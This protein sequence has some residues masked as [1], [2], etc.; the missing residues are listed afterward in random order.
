M[1]TLV[2]EAFGEL[3][4]GVGMPLTSDDAE[5]LYSLFT[6]RAE[7]MGWST[8]GGRRRPLLWGMNDAALT[9][10]ADG[11]RIGWVQVGLQDGVEP[12]LALPALI[13]CFHDALGRFGVVDLSGLQVAGSE[14]QS[15]RSCA[16]DLISGLNWFNAAPH[17]KSSAVIVIDDQSLEG[18]TDTE[19]VASLQRLNTGGF[20]FGPQP[21][22]AH[23]QASETPDRSIPISDHSRLGMSVTLPEWSATAVAWALA[24]VID[25]AGAGGPGL[26][27]FTA[28]LGV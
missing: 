12:V 10:G 1:P 3:E 4:S 18:R 6:A 20:E 13:Q 2:V 11:A 8:T 16:A 19:L 14:L 21:T 7:L 24:I 15:A 23:H 26:R 17:A 27:S 9:V 25:T 28:R 22:M 5:D